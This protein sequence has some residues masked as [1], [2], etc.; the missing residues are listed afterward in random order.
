MTKLPLLFSRSHSLP[1]LAIRLV[2]WDSSSGA[3]GSG[4]G[5]GGGGTRTGA[6]SGTG[7]GGYCE[8]SGVV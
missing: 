6:T 8:I 5:A 7:S 4:Y 3:N 1:A 2:T